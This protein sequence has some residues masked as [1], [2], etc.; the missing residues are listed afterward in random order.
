MFKVKML[1]GLKTFC[2]L[3]VCERNAR[4]CTY[5]KLTASLLDDSL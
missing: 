2:R 4:Q 3:Q 5:D 1:V